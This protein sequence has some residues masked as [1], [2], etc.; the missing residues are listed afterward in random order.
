MRAAKLRLRYSIRGVSFV[1]PVHN[2]ALCLRR[3]LEAIV[4]QEAACPIEII[5]VDDHSDDGSLALV[6]RLP[7]VVAAA[8][9]VRGNAGRRGGDERGRPRGAL[10]DHLSGR[11]G[12]RGWAGLD[13]RAVDELDDPGV[14]AVQGYY[15][16]DP[17]ADCAARAMGARPRAALR[18]PSAARRPITSA[19]ATRCI[20]RRR[21]TSRAASTSASA[22][23]TTTT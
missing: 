9:G 14:G 12:R 18:A 7:E 5:V 3:A 19:P 16:T 23:A 20:A 6:R 2:G 11:S 10:S 4:A 22:T 8:S 15:V 1:V 21:C 17:A 13:D